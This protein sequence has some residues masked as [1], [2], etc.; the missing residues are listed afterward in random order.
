MEI[1]TIKVDDDYDLC[2]FFCFLLDSFGDLGECVISEI[3]LASESM[4]Y[5]DLISRI[6]FMIDKKLISER[7]DKEKS[8]KI[9]S[10]LTEG[11][12]IAREL[13]YKIPLSIREKTLEIGKETISR[14]E[15]EKATR[16]YINYDYLRNRYDLVVKFLNEMNGEIILEIRLYAPDEAKAK[17]MKERF[18]SRPSLTITRTM[19]LF[20][21]DDYF[22]FE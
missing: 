13:A 21:N 11:K 9:Y 5:F 7:H 1:P 20:L 19:N 6:G 15:R 4:N 10:L 14:I 2:I 12:T 3:V 18:L 16:C 17:E 8:E 22:L